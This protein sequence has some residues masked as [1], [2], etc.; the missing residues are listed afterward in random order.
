LKRAKKNQTSIKQDLMD[1]EEVDYSSDD[2]AL[3][4]RRV[5]REKLMKAEKKEEEEQEQEIPLGEMVGEL[6]KVKVENGT[7]KGE[8]MEGEDE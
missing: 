2:E 8:G 3:I 7:L 1:D 5:K 6:D 4:R